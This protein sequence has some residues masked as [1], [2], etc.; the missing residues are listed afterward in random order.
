[1]ERDRERLI[2]RTHWLGVGGNV[3]LAALKLGVGA[4]AGSR[5]LLAD[6]VHSTSDVAMNVGAWIGWRWSSKPRDRDHHYGHGNGEALTAVA[7]GVIVVAAG[8]GLLWTALRGHSS[9]GPDAL[10]VAAVSVEVV[11]MGLKY[12]LARVTARRGRELG[13]PILVALSRDNAADVLTSA[14]VMFAII[15]AIF[16]LSWLEPFAA[17]A[18]GLIIVW[19]GLRSAREGIGVLMDRAPDHALTAQIAEIAGGVGGVCSVDDVRVHPLGNHLRVDLEIGVDGTIS[20]AQ[21]HGI[22]HAVERAVTEACA[23]VGEVAV[24]VNPANPPIG[25]AADSPA[26]SA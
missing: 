15:G 20:V 1:M 17:A 25:P 10:G 14:L 16:G 6:G 26:P 4:L 7:I 19:H 8:I 22:A 24:H 3:L 21:G 9:V 13:S 11:S 12:G 2:T 18:V 23:G 5:A